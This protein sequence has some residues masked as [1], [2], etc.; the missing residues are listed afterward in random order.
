VDGQDE[1]GADIEGIQYLGECGET[2]G[3]YRKLMHI[4]YIHQHFATPAGST[5]TRSYEFSKRWVKASHKVTLITGHYDIG[6]LEVGKGLYQKQTIDGINVIIVGTKYSNKQSYLRRIISFLSFCLFSI[7]VGLRVE[8]VDVIYATSTP[9][10]VGIP[11]MVIKWL[12]RKPFVFEV[13]DQWPETPIEMGIIKNRILIK[14][15]LWLEKTIYR[16]SSAIVALSSPMADDVRRI[17][18]QD[19]SITVIPNSCDAEL[20]RP[21]IDGSAIRREKGWDDKLVFLHAG[22]MGKITGLEFIID[23]ADKLRCYQDILF[24]LVGEGFRKGALQ[25]KVREFGLTNV[26]ILQSVPKQQL[27]SILAA[28]D[29]AIVIIGN[30]PIIEKHASLNKFYDGLSSGKPVLLNYSGWQRDLL[31]KNNAGYGCKLCDVNEFAEKV[32]YL[33]SHREELIEMGRNARR[34]AEEKF[35]R[36]KLAAQAMSV[37]EAVLN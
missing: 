32:L 25:N 15:L 8:N 35:D 9:L 23:V 24:V 20:F 13:R 22:A 6:G 14:I 11:A 29:V 10:T 36:D 7:Y 21:S 16:Q 5:G 18:T 1:P 26:E 2:K 37:L 17:L 33:N 3:A 19:K 31:E 4:L 30:F 28:A 12:R 34:A 27:P